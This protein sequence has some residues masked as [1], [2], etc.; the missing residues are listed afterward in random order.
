MFI[1]VVFCFLFLQDSQLDVLCPF[2]AGIKIHIPLPVVPGLGR[3][4]HLQQRRVPNLAAE[5][6]RARGRG[7][8]FRGLV[9]WHG[10]GLQPFWVVWRTR[11]LGPEV[12]EVDW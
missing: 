10:G 4:F 12:G 2:A 8:S 3:S 9:A 7:E 1:K 5:R 6:S 11:F